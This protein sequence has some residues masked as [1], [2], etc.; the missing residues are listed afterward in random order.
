MGKII[1]IYLPTYT[2]KSAYVPIYLENCKSTNQATVTTVSVL[3]RF[4]RFKLTQIY[5]RDE[6]NERL[7]RQFT[8]FSS[9]RIY[10]TVTR[11][12]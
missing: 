10:I 3:L 9:R 1:R 6:I 11:E 5:I 2:P 8:L 4:K 12:R 7:P